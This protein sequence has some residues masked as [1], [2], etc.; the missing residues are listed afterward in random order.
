MSC[1]YCIEDMDEPCKQCGAIMSDELAA[2][3]SRLDAARTVIERIHKRGWI[4][5]SWSDWEHD[6][7]DVAALMAAIVVEPVIPPTSEPHPEGE[8]TLWIKP[9]T[10][11]GQE[12]KPSSPGLHISPRHP[13]E[14]PEDQRVTINGPSTFVLQGDPIII[15]NCTMTA[16][17]PFDRFGPSL[18]PGKYWI[19]V[20]YKGDPF[21]ATDTIRDWGEEFLNPMYIK[22]TKPWSESDDE[23]LPYLGE[24]VVVK[25]A[26]GT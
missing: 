3:Q 16:W 1:K 23:P 13:N 26:D 22:A 18:P 11:T 14:V 10:Y 12:L 19:T 2:L 21:V 8:V 4:D 5:E 17:T 25:R 6:T 24:G 15:E 20:H 9:G 7:G